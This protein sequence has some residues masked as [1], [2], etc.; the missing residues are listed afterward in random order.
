MVPNQQVAA[1]CIL[2]RLNAADAPEHE[3]LLHSNAATQWRKA[4]EPV[5]TAQTYLGFDSVLRSAGLV[6]GLVSLTSIR[7][8]EKERLDKW[9]FSSLTDHSMYALWVTSTSL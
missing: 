3:S 1:G 2:L 9:G 8:L 6:S 4:S 5:L 7:R